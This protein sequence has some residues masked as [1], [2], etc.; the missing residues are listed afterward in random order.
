VRMLAVRN[1]RTAVL[2]MEPSPDCE[3]RFRGRRAGYRYRVEGRV[4]AS[5]AP[6][7]VDLRL[8]GGRVCMEMNGPDTLA[9]NSRGLPHGFHNR[10][11]WVHERGYAD[12]LFLSVVG[13]VRRTR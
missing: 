2:V 11:V 13:R 6:R 3:V 5:M 9:V 1:G 4:P 8:A 7:L 12:S 10:T